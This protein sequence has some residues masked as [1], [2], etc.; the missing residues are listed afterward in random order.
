MVAVA[1]ADQL[2]SI[3]SGTGH[4]GDGDGA[5]TEVDHAPAQRGNGAAGAALR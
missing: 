3:L 1:L 2:G 4:A 5:R